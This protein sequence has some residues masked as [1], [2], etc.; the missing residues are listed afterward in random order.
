MIPRLTGCPKATAPYEAFMREVSRRG[1]QGECSSGYGDRLAISTDNS[2]YQ[3]LPEAVLYPRHVEDL[4]RI[5]TL[6]V[7]PR[8]EKLTF[9]PRGGGMADRMLPTTRILP[10]TTRVPRDEATRTPFN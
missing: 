10:W 5:A 1:F 9:T 3:R 7:D 6:A 8:F 4:V 2:I